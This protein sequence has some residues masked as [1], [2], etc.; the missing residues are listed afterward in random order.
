MRVTGSNTTFSKH[1]AE[2][3]GGVPDLRLGL[4]AK[5]DALGVAAALEIE[6]AVRTPTVFIITNQCAVGIGRQRGLAGAGQAEE[7][8]AVAVRPDIGRAM[9]RHDVFRRQIEV[10]RG[11]HRL[12]HF[13]GVRRAADQHDLAGEIDRH[14]GV[15]AFAPAVPLGIGPERRQ[16]DDRE[17]G[18]EAGELGAL[19]PDQQLPDEQRMP[20]VFGEDARLDPI[21]RIGAA[22]EILREEFLAFGVCEKIGEQIVEVL[23]RHFAV[24]VPPHRIL[25]ERV[26]DG[27]LVLRAAAGVV[28]GLGAERAAFDQRGFASGDGVLVERGF[29]EVPVD[30]GEIFEAEFVGAMS[31]VPHTRFLHAKSSQRAGPKPDY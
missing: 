11:E 3:V 18:H 2:A 21:F 31:A 6:D 24:T 15:G 14:H 1:R 7:Q 23:L 5:L 8:R 27:V 20:G 30:R 10:E 28:T 26:D 25:G 22:V 16:I 13:A 29:G 4:L 17:F 9:H 12:L 19:G